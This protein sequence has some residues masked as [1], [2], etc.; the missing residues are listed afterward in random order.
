MSML[1]KHITIYIN[2]ITKCQTLIAQQLQR[3]KISI[4]LLIKIFMKGSR[5][6]NLQ[7]SYLISHSVSCLT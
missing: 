4:M 3:I 6:E 7:K 5:I 2:I 1:C